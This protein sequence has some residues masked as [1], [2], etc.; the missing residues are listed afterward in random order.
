MQTALAAEAEVQA[1]LDEQLQR[2]AGKEAAAG[3]ARVE[4]QRMAEQAEGARLDAQRTEEDTARRQDAVN[5]KV[6]DRCPHHL[7]VGDRNRSTR[8]CKQQKSR[9]GQCSGQRCPAQHVRWT[10]DCKGHSRKRQQ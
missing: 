5:A 8:L 9:S 10:F 4:V 1:A 3:S 6:T 7:P 2:L